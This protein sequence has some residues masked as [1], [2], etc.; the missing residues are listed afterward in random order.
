M[1]L[2][3]SHICSAIILIVFLI[4][5]QANV[6]QAAYELDLQYTAMDG[7]LVN[8]DQYE[9]KPLL[10]DAWA[11]WCEPCKTTMVDLHGIYSAFG[12]NL[13]VLSVSV[14][15]ETDTLV[16]IQAFKVELE[17]DN[18]IE[19]TWDFGLD[20][21]SQISDNFEISFLPSLVLL[22]REGNELEFWEG[23][24]DP[25]IVVDVIN[26]KFDL[27]A[28]YVPGDPNDQL[29]NQLL[30]NTPFRIT[31]GLVAILFIYTVF[32][33]KKKSVEDITPGSEI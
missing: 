18:D 16:K 3:S 30:N 26:S 9:G 1:K 27:N 28:N 15:P 17:E 13:S 31:V 10:I 29:L 21:D 11:T 14:S 33:P 2:N 23:I 5:T 24:T 7:T 25:Q 20:H 6:T 4:M 8:L 22:D 12:G 19:M 32:V